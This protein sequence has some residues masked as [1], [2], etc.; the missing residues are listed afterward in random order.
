MLGVGWASRRYGS[1]L[2]LCARSEWHHLGPADIALY[3]GRLRERP[4]QL[5]VP[6]VSS[7]TL[8]H[9][10][11]MRPR[12][13]RVELAIRGGRNWMQLLPLSY[14][15]TSLSSRSGKWKGNSIDFG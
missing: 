14:T 5:A 2:Y 9:N 11:R 3:V 1:L 8:Y 4:I 13:S 6:S 7:A 15:I 12:R 10:L